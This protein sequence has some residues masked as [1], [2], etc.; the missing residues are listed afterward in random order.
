VQSVIEA[1]VQWPAPSQAAAPLS[2]VALHPAAA[3]GVP[4]E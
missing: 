3:Q 1:G 4:P 2:V